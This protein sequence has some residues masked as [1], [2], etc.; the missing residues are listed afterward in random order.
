MSET[1]FSQFE[2]FV[3]SWQAVDI[4]F[5]D[6]LKKFLLEMALRAVRQIK[7][8]QAGK[9]GGDSA[10][11]TGA[12]LNTWFIGSQNIVLKEVRRRKD[13]TTMVIDP[14]QSTVADINVIENSFEVVIG[15]PQEYASFIEYGSRQRGTGEWREGHF[16]MT[17]SVDEV[18]RQIPAR[19]E[20]ALKAY[21]ASKGAV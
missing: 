20:A 19:F 13:G 21:L 9:L 2:A 5:E 8:R 6:F 11:D 12:M 1:D 15:N 16:M 4:E 10:V 3:K 18:Q 14:E 7:K 17:I